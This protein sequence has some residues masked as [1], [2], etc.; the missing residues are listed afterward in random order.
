MSVRSCVGRAGRSTR[1][2]TE[3]PG[4][5]PDLRGP[6]AVR[7]ARRR[8]ASGSSGARSSTS[9]RPTSATTTAL[10]GIG[11]YAVVRDRP[12]RAARQVDRRQRPLGL[13]AVPRRRDRRAHRR[14]RR[15]RGDRDLASAL[16]LR[17]GRMGARVRL[18]DPICTKPSASGC[19]VPIRRCASGT[20]RRTSS[21]AALTL[22]RCGGHY[23]G[24][25]VLHWPERRALLTGDIVQVIPDRRYV[26]FMYSYPNLIPLPAVE[27]AARSRTPS[28][29]STFE[30]IYGAWCGRVDRARRLSRRPPV[31][32]PLRARDHRARARLV[33]GRQSRSA[34][35]SRK[36]SEIAG[37]AGRPLRFSQTVSAIV[38]AERRRRAPTQVS[39]ARAGRSARRREE[40]GEE[41]QVGNAEVRGAV[42]ARHREREREHG[43]D[44]RV[45]LDDLLR[46]PAPHRVRVDPGDDAG[47]EDDPARPSRSSS[48]N[49]QPRSV[50]AARRAKFAKTSKSRERQQRGE[51]GEREPDR[52]Q[53]PRRAAAAARA[54][55][56]R[57]PPGSGRARATRRPTRGR[58]RQRSGAIS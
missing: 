11:C 3:P 35:G 9:T 25:Q 36:P 53:P 19:C 33:A 55:R 7:P 46:R 13:H 12:A 16:L 15:A 48:R 45:V 40:E 27:G 51:H 49:H 47:D 58:V 26:S 52:Q 28:R 21:A 31:G 18:P 8:P 43:E 42:L 23:E 4:R 38:A 34:F 5:V 2:P 56:A 29:R 32:R 57:T 54:A 41:E 30:T 22:I 1:R 10:L 6:A 24:G 37:S 44:V 39:A 17:D 50:V 20:A 14:R